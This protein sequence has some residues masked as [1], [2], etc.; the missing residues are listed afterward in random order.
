MRPSTGSTSPRLHAGAIR[1][2][3]RRRTATDWPKSWGSRDS[4]G[5]DHGRIHSP[6]TW[7]N[8]TAPHARVSTAIRFSPLR[9]AINCNWAAGRLG[10]AAMRKGGTGMPPPPRPCQVQW[11]RW[12]ARPQGREGIPLGGGGRRRGHPPPETK[13]PP[14][15]QESRA[16]SQG[17]PWTAFWSE[18]LGGNQEDVW[19][20]RGPSP[21]GR[22][23]LPGNRLRLFPG[24]GK[25][26]GVRLQGR[27]APWTGFFV[28]VRGRG[29]GFWCP[30]RRSSLGTTTR[31]PPPFLYFLL[32]L[33]LTL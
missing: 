33:Y 26:L 24:A 18:L 22:G 28:D 3:A 23:P 25:G 32:H 13:E 7:W 6:T 31:P 15:S 5:R 17:A 27:G 16:R 14:K 4:R 21:R 2:W 29:K 10:A 12:P 11:H 30:M 20:L 1:Q 9:R 19:L 8:G